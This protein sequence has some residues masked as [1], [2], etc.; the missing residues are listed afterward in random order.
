M[1]Y[2]G[3]DLA[4]GERSPTGVA[5]LDAGGQLVHLSAETTDESI[6]TALAPY[7]D[8][9]VLAGIDAPLVVTNA[10]GN[11][12]CE[13]ALNRDFAAFDAGAH[14]ANTGKPE[15]AG[16]PR[17]ARLA[18]ALGL[19]INPASG[20]ER[21]GIEV[22]PHPA[23]VVLFGLGRTLK[24]K[25]RG[26]R[27]LTQLREALQ[28]LVDHVEALAGAEPAMVVTEH[29]GWRE[30]A[31]AVRTATRKSQLR[32]AEDQVD[33]VLCAYVARFAVAHP[34]RMTTYGDLATGYIIT[35]TLPEGRVPTPRASAVGPAAAG[36]AEP[37]AASEAAGPAA[38]SETDAGPATPSSPTVAQPATDPVQRAVQAYAAQRPELER[39]TAQY[40]TLITGLLDDAGINYHAVTGRT[41][42]VASFAG[43][44]ART[45]D[46]RPAFS[47][48]LREITDQIGLRIVTYVLSD[49]QAV[50]ELL[51]DQLVM[52]GDRDMGLETAQ[53][54]RFGYASRH[55]LVALDAGRSGEPELARLRDRTAS[56]Q[57]RTVL[58][59]AWAEF[60]HDIRYKGSIPEKVAPDLDR[61]FTLAAGLLDL[62]DRE[63]STIRDRLQESMPDQEPQSDETDPR[64]SAQDLAAFLAGRFTDAGWSRTDHYAWVSGLLLE[65][66]VTSLLELG[67]LLRPVDSA[68]ISERM[69]YRY[70]PGAVRRLDDALLGV[71]GD[72]YVQ[73]HGNARRRDALRARLAKLRD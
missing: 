68:V 39:T 52:L 65:L 2:V 14:P 61:R 9:P 36:E 22:Y 73:L 49:V 62:A 4:W 54:G 3:I 33:A 41:K 67:E 15:F 50:V 25:Q 13:A 5:V 40:V 69:G 30:L 11:R 66:G 59:H 19:D 16:T 60:E 57:V 51:A 44:A 6:L 64:I 10:T 12:P 45:V 1:H 24:Y 31:T 46:G 70:A 53:E 71:F 43:K 58:Q 63:F 23:T 28:T 29:A 47:D 72:R 21:R 18:K 26:G 17:G 42:S 37:A 34:E 20:R 32:V 48:P 27:D 35:P 38:A 7:R 56:V 8:G 55:V